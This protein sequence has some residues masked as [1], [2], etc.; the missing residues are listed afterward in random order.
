MEPTLRVV[1]KQDGVMISTICRKGSLLSTLIASS[2][3]AFTLDKSVPRQLEW[4]A[5]AVVCAGSHVMQTSP[6]LKRTSCMLKVG[7]FE[8]RYAEYDRV[9]QGMNNLTVLIGENWES[10]QKVKLASKND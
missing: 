9:T 4:K 8:R 6:S 3:A 7:I 10:T 5:Y 1:Q 2:E